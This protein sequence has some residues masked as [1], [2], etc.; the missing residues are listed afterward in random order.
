M[1][2]SLPVC[3]SFLAAAIT[4]SWFS[5]VTLSGGCHSCSACSPTT[6]AARHSSTNTTGCRRV[7]PM[8]VIDLRNTRSHQSAPMDI[9]IGKGNLK[10]RGAVSRRR[11]DMLNDWP[12][13]DRYWL[14]SVVRCPIT[15]AYKTRSS[16]KDCF[17]IR[18]SIDFR[19]AGAGRWSILFIAMLPCLTWGKTVLD[20]YN[21]VVS[22]WRTWPISGERSNPAKIL[23]TLDNLPAD[24]RDFQQTQ[25]Q[26][27][28]WCAP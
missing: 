9:E 20:P 8:T 17:L 16:H 28:R 26:R 13:Y 11:F 4:C 2:G 21:Q 24:G 12:V 23:P 3:A 15:R 22:A 6:N 5:A 18:K 25:S 7:P 1:H 27:K 19:R 10:L 14:T